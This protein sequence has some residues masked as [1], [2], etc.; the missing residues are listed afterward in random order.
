MLRFGFKSPS[1][2][3]ATTTTPSTAAPTTT[4]TGWKRMKMSLIIIITSLTKKIIKIF[5]GLQPVLRIWIRSFW[6]TRIRIL[7][8]QKTLVILISSLYKIVL[9]DPDP[10]RSG[11]F[12]VTRIRILITGSAGYKKNGPDPQ[13]WLQHYWQGLYKLTYR[14]NDFYHNDCTHNKKYINHIC[15]DNNCVVWQ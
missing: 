14:E 15:Y 2:C 4:T 10:V 7:Y 5:F 1:C 9:P 3:P 12:W 8:P 13:H 6:V 11:L